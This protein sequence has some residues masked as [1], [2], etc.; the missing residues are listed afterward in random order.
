MLSSKEMMIVYEMLPD[1]PGMGNSVKITMNVSR[2][3][4]LLMAKVMEGGMVIKDDQPGLFSIVDEQT[5]AELKKLP[6][7]ILEKAGLTNLNKKLV[8]LS[9]K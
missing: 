1:F 6:E 9:A 3:L 7:E 5:L 8:A 4:A 2:K